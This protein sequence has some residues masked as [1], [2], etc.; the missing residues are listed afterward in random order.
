MNCYFCSQFR[1]PVFYYYLG[2]SNIT[3][4]DV[5]IVTD[6]LLPVVSVNVNP[7]FIYIG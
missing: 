5:E 7:G 3:V 4:F 6:V 2:I 1:Y